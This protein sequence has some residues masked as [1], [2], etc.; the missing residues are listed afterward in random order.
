LSLHSRA[1]L[2]VDFT[3]GWSDFHRLA[4]SDPATAVNA[5]IK[6]YVH[7]DILF[8]GGKTIRL[9][10][11]ES[12]EHVTISSPGQL[13]YDGRLDRHKAAL[14]MLPLSVGIEILT[15][16]EAPP[17]SGLG[18]KAALD[19]ALLS[20]LALGR[21]EEYDSD[22][23][24]ELGTMLE[25]NELSL[26][27][28]RQDHYATVCGG[29]NE[30]VF[31]ETEV[32]VRKVSL[33]QST[34]ADLERH[35][36]LVYTG[37]SHFSKQTHDRVVEAYCGGVKSVKGAVADIR[38]TGREVKSVLQGGDWATLGQLFDR[39]WVSQQILDAATT[40][41]NVREIENAIREN[42]AWG[43]KPTGVGCGGCLLTVAP[44]EKMEA[45]R[46]A[47]LKLGVDTFD[48]AFEPDGCSVVQKEDEAVE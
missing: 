40:T 28:L 10:A 23:L 48:V 2:R 39:Q 8:V 26:P 21:M 18:A 45:V 14:N 27:V 38:S 15:R 17:G 32:A 11:E 24:V 6:I 41:P 34:L 36:L 20:A 1:P 7:A 12:R 30:L 4:D 25:A 19:A 37:E 9:H 3:G 31:D 5:A 22:E 35:L 46:K 13:V 47:V 33:P 29:F 16:T 43:V 44:P 42:G